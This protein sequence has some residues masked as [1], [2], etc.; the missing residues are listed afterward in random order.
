MSLQTIQQ[1]REAWHDMLREELLLLNEAD[2]AAAHQYIVTHGAPS[3]AERDV[4]ISAAIERDR[5]SM[6]GIRS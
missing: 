1:I 2:F 6:E 5:R 3:V 4:F